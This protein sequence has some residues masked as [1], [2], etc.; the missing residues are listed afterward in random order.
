MNFSDLS[1]LDQNYI[2]SWPLPVRIVILIAVMGGVLGAGWYFDINNQR[3][4]R[5]EVRAEE[6]NLKSTFETKQ[7]KA[8]NLIP[9]KAQME[10]MKQTF[11]D[12]LRQ[13]PSKTEVAGL[14]VDVSQQGLASGLEF[15][16]FQPASEQPAEFYVE[17]PIRIRVTG[18][19][20]EFGEFASGVAALP[21]IVTQHDISIKSKGKGVL[22]METTAKTYR[23]VD[24]EEEAAQ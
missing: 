10:E 5:D 3:I 1:N 9:L 24:E 20:H 8:A 4:K 16:L 17:L 2:G 22:T 12:L 13:L 14:L 15:E 21:R 7:R 23:Y 6:S 19:Y 18:N 11:G